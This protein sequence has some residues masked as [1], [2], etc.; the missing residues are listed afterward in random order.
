MMPSGGLPGHLSVWID[1]GHVGH[2]RRSSITTNCHGCWL[3]PV[4]AIIAADRNLCT[5]SSGTG[6]SSYFRMLRR[7]RMASKVSIP[8]SPFSLTNPIREREKHRRP[9]IF[10][11]EVHLS[12]GRNSAKAFCGRV[13]WYTAGRSRISPS[14]EGYGDFFDLKGPN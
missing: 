12:T 7:V 3:R 13:T 6:R 1:L 2:I 9:L 14:L 10:G 4:G 5:N 8:I 11:L